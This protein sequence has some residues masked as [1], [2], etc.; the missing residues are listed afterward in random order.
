MLQTIIAMYLVIGAIDFFIWYIRKGP[1]DFQDT[2]GEK[3]Q[4][5]QQNE[6]WLLPALFVLNTLLWLPMYL[7]KLR[8]YIAKKRRG[9][10]DDAD[11]RY[12]CFG[13]PDCNYRGQT[14]QEVITHEREKH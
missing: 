10:G 11:A 5:Y 1:A 8:Q 9:K 2:L 3:K 14:E 6:Y 12:R 7:N 4:L 13:D